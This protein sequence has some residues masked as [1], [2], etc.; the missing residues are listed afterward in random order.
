MTEEWRRMARE[1]GFDGL[2]LI[3]VQGFK[4]LNPFTIGLDA[5]CEF[6]T[7]YQCSAGITHKVDVASGGPVCKSYDSLLHRVR[8]LRSQ[9]Y[10]RYKCIAP[11][12]DNTPRKAERGTLFTDVTTKKFTRLV[13]KASMSILADRRL[14]ENGFLFVNAWNEWGE[15]AHLEPDLRY[16]YGWLETIAKVMD[17][18]MEHL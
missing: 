13:T 9:E 16:G 8:S 7:P 11:S 3:S 1:A 2:Y 15:G 14:R 18:T 4:A 10:V 6:A 12:W 5:A 17:K